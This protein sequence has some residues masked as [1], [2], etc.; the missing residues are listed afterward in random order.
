MASQEEEVRLVRKCCLSSQIPSQGCENTRRA[1]HRPQQCFW[2]SQPPEP[3]ATQP[4]T[5]YNLPSLGY[6]VIATRSELAHL[7]NGTH[8]VFFLTS[9]WWAPNC[10]PSFLS[11]LWP[12]LEVQLGQSLKLQSGLCFD[13]KKSITC[14]ASCILE[15]KPFM[16]PSVPDPCRP[17]SQPYTWPYS[18]YVYLISVFMWHGLFHLMKFKPP[19]LLSDHT[20][21]H[22]LH[23]KFAKLHLTVHFRCAFFHF[24]WT[25]FALVGGSLSINQTLEDKLFRQEKLF[26]KTYSHMT[27]H[28]CSAYTVLALEV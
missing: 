24:A 7:T 25:S 3:W 13:Q 17:Q 10:Y 6:F 27:C 9:F 8:H 18:H 11:C 26:G 19:A 16:L 21:I 1:H 22:L 20:P 23:P 15:E 5:L 12:S 4:S 28:C 14:I 2:I